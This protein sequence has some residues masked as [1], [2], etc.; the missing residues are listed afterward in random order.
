MENLRTGSERGVDV[1]ERI[2]R[3]RAD[4]A[5]DAAFDVGQQHVLLRF[6]EAVDFIDEQDG[7]LAAHVAMVPGLIDFCAD[8]RDV[9][10]DTVDRLEARPGHAC[11]HR[12]QSGFPRPRRTIENQRR[13]A[14]GLD[15]ASQQL[16]GGEDVL[17]SGDLIQM[18]RSHPRGQRLVQ[19]ILRLGLLE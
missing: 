2:V 5:D 8:L 9:G 15:G 14:V 3:G 17:L 1:E 18:M 11:D 4:E 16:A 13:E 10:F 6:V 19:G 12:G 7:G